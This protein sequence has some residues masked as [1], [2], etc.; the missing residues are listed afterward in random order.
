MWIYSKFMFQSKRRQHFEGYFSIL[1]Y[2]LL[3]KIDSKHLPVRK[4][5]LREEIFAG[6]KFAN[7]GQI[8]KV[9]FLF[10]APKMSIHEN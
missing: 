7:F 9:K 10:R 4:Y 6:R 2:L 3:C 1:F 5:P 8:R